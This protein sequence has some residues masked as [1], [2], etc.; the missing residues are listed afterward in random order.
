MPTVWDSA[1]DPALGAVQWVAK[2]AA[3][4]DAV[5]GGWT[6]SAG[7]DLFAMIDEAVYSAS[8]YGT[9]TTTPN[10]EY[11]CTGSWVASI[12]AAWAPAAINGVVGY[13]AVRGDSL[14]SAS[15]IAWSSGGT[16]AHGTTT[17]TSSTSVVLIT[18]TLAVNPNGSAAWTTT[19]LNTLQFGVKVS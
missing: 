4:A 11:R 5:A 10:D 15:E 2:I 19:M 17:A 1:S 8:D 13:A 18:D 3:N 7:G 12:D 16:A 14:L 6:P 9:T